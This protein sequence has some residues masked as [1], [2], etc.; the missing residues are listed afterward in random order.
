MGCDHGS[1]DKPHLGQGT[2][3]LE[4]PVSRTG[5]SPSPKRTVS[6]S[7]CSSCTATRLRRRLIP[8]VSGSE[9]ENHALMAD[10][11]PMGSLVVLIARGVLTNIWCVSNVGR[12]IATV[13]RGQLAA[14]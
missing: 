3:S 8:D 13:R 7:E 12:V 5:H 11:A 10:L 14:E 2:A 6:I 4:R 9:A 1:W